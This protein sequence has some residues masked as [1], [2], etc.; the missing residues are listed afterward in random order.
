MLC[1]AVWWHTLTNCNW[2]AE[3]LKDSINYITIGAPKAPDSLSLPTS[4]KKTFSVKL[5]THAPGV[6]RL[7]G[8]PCLALKKWKPKF[9]RK[10]EGGCAHTGHQPQKHTRLGLSP[11]GGQSGQR[12]AHSPAQAAFIREGTGSSRSSRLSQQTSH[13]MGKGRQVVP[14]GAP[15]KLQSQ[16]LALERRGVWQTWV[17]PCCCL[18]LSGLCGRG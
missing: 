3:T 15:N 2:W 8:A 17:S 5:L 4:F 10:P 7:T 6:L 16:L 14:A 18:R 12:L 9:K 1:K 13:M 11:S